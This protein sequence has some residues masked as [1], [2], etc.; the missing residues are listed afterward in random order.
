[1]FSIKLFCTAVNKEA[2]YEKMAH[3]INFDLDKAA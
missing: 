2:D 3:E 1:M